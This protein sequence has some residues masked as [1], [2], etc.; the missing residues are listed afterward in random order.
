MIFGLLVV[1]FP[2]FNLVKPGNQALEHCWA[3]VKLL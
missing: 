1:P 3:M 2:E